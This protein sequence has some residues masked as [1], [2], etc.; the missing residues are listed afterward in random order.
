M[1]KSI[2]VYTKTGCIYCSKLESLMQQYNIPYKKYTSTTQ[3]DI[4][5][6]KSISKMNTYP[7]VFFNTECIGG[8][9]EFQSLLMTNSLEEKLKANGIKDINIQLQF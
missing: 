3:K 8:F 1:K 5:D 7:M 2:T 4:D 6:L 9:S